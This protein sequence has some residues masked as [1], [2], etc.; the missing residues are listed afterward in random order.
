VLIVSADWSRMPPSPLLSEVMPQAGADAASGDDQA[1][2][3][4]LLDLL[5]ADPDQRQTMLEDYLTVLA[6]RVLRLD[7]TKLDAREALTSYGMDSIMVVELKHHIERKLN[8]SIAIVDLFTGSV[9][10]LAEQLA[11]KL[12]NDTRLEQLLEQV[13]N[14]SPQELEQLLGQAEN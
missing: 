13:E 8:L 3:A 14:M 4:M 5:L 10:K 7:P 2:A 11:G 6:A 1:A 12:A 9:V